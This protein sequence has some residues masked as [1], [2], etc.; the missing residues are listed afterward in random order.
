MAV[1]IL[2]LVVLVTF[3]T[4]F[5]LFLLRLKLV[6][7]LF[8][9]H[10]GSVAAF[11]YGGPPRHEDRELSP[12]PLRLHND[13]STAE[14]NRLHSFAQLAH[15]LIRGF[16]QAAPFVF[17]EQV[18]RNK[19]IAGDLTFPVLVHLCESHSDLLCPHNRLGVVVDFFFLAQAK[20]GGGGLLASQVQNQ[21]LD[22]VKLQESTLVVVCV[23]KTLFD[24]ILL[25]LVLRVHAKQLHFGQIGQ[26]QTDLD[27]FA[28]RR[29]QSG[30]SSFVLVHLCAG[31]GIGF[32]VQ[33]LDDAGDEL[34]V[35]G[36]LFHEPNNLVL[37]LV[38]VLLLLPNHV[39]QIVNL[40]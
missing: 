26:Q 40:S 28:K 13:V 20:F 35:H 5:L 9:R 30:K 36:V 24:H 37:D 16:G 33:V 32:E 4:L 21:L 19:L 2:L 6:R 12:I 8:V 39:V 14:S 23:D 15:E 10:D 31:S 29:R 38:V 1:F 3:F 22:L 7:V 25:G 17:L 11:V 18:P 27:L 34:V